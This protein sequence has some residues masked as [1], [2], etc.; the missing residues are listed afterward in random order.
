VRSE[1]RIEPFLEN[2]KVKNL[3]EYLNNSYKPKQNL[4]ARLQG[5][6]V[7]DVIFDDEKQNSLK[8]EFE[9]KDDLIFRKGEYY[10]TYRIQLFRDGKSVSNS[11]GDGRLNFLKSY[12]EKS[13]GFILQTGRLYFHLYFGPSRRFMFG[14]THC[15][16]ALIFKSMSVSQCHHFKVL[17]Q[18]KLV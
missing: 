4:Y 5:L 2:V 17:S 7:G 9:L 15:W 14:I 12:D 16:V 13:K 11:D 3:F 8:M 6:F 1:N 10:G 18:L